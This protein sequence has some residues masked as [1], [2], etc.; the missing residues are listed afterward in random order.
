MLKIPMIC[1]K[2]SHLSKMDR[3]LGVAQLDA[4]T[5]Q[6]AGFRLSVHTTGGILF[7]RKKVETPNLLFDIQYLYNSLY[8]SICLRN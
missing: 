5:L 3:E 2:A 4:G 6:P 1:L 7:L 8:V